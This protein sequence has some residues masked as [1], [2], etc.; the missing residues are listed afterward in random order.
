MRKSTKQSAWWMIALL[1][2]ALSWTAC[3]DDDGSGD[4]DAGEQ[5]GRSG[6]AGR[7]G[8]GGSGGS[9][10]D[11]DAGVAGRAGSKAAA[12]KGGSSG[13]GGC[14]SGEPKQTS[15]YLNHCTDSECEPFDNKARL[16]LLDGDKLPPLP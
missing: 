4:N 3:G 7:G 8:R 12:G 2:S 15:Q 9:S 13:A 5:A 6:R 1:I 16:P 10:D 14:Y 11:D